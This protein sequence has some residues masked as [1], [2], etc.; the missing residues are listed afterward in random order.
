M[1]IFSGAVQDLQLQ[2]GA[3][4]VTSLG[5]VSGKEQILNLV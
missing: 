5:V 2:L 4:P 1:G 3:S